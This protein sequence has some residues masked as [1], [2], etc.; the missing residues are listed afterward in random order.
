[1]T[2]IIIN[3]F[4]FFYIKLNVLDKDAIKLEKISQKKMKGIEDEIAKKHKRA[5]QYE[6]RIAK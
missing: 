3:I 6:A 5:Q 2:Y 1:V 4:I